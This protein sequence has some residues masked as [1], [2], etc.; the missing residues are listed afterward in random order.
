MAG[1]QSAVEVLKRSGNS[2]FEAIE[3]VGDRVVALV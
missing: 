1:Q 2:A 3:H